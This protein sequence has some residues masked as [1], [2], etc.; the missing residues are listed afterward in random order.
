[1]ELGEIA[2]LKRYSI[3]VGSVFK[4]TLYPQDGVTPKNEGE[5]SR[6]KYFVIIGKTTDGIVVGSLLINTNI[7]DNLKDVIGPYQHC[8]HP[9]QYD[10]LNGKDRYIDCYRIKELTF[11]RLLKGGIYIGQ[12]ETDDIAEVTKL[13]KASPVNNR[14]TLK[15]FSLL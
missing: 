14:H 2:A 9:D 15:K 3:D 5:S 7:N 1:M 11:E 13:V 12:I 6:N 8:I 10:F 4:M